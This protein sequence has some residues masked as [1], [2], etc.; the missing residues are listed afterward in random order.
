MGGER[1]PRGAGIPFSVVRKGFDPVEVREFFE[2]FDAEGIEIDILVNNAGIQL[3][4][5]MVELATDEWRKVIEANL[6][7]AF[8]IGREAAKRMIP[9][10]RGKIVNIGS[11][12]SAGL[13]AFGQ[14]GDE[15]DP[16]VHEAVQHETSPEVSGPTVT[17]VL[18]RGYRFGDRVLRPAMVAV[19]DHEPESAATPPESGSGASEEAGQ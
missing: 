1:D 16:S 7:S 14:E 13:E 2:R 19:T 6:T 5:P 4:K 8:V 15:F 18:R 3:R 11:L 9:R 12:T 10:G 17:T